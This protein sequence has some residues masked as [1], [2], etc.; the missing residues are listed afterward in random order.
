[1]NDEKPVLGTNEREE[2]RDRLAR[3][4]GRLLAH[5]W[6]RSQQSEVTKLLDSGQTSE[7]AEIDDDRESQVQCASIE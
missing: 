1:M 6:L 2:A 7:G 4:I 5:E 3:Q